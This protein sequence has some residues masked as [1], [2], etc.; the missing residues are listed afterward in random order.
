MPKRK[1]ERDWIAKSQPE[2]SRA[3]GV[4]YD[5]IKGWCRRGLSKDSP[6]G[7]SIAHVW[8][9]YHTEGPGREKPQAGDP[10]LEADGDSPGLE[11]YRLAKAEHA[12]LDLA[13]R[14]KE[15]ISV[16]ELRQLLGWLLSPIKACVERASIMCPQFASDFNDAMAEFTREVD[17]R[18]GDTGDSTD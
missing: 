8:N 14:R 1:T 13:E 16:A 3:I 17:K 7:Y 18:F 15:L 6:K 11:R 4:P 2:L 10:L 9:W 12:E 5:T